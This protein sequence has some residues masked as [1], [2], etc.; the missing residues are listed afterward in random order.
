MHHL[1]L[2]SSEFSSDAAVESG[3]KTPKAPIGFRTK[4][5]THLRSPWICGNLAL[6]WH[7]HELPM[8]E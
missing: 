6:V 7:G 8:Y 1:N 3:P 2:L 5:S 4:V